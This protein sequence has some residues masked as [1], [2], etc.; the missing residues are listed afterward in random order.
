MFYVL[1]VA[2]FFLLVLGPGLQPLGLVYSPWSWFFTARSY[3]SR[4]ILVYSHVLVHTFSALA[5]RTTVLPTAN[6]EF[7]HQNYNLSAGKPDRIQDVR[8]QL[9]SF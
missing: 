5:S 2:H 4:L 7:L 6:T 1:F 3:L 9:H 8:T